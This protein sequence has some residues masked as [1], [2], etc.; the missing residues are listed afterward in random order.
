MLPY[1]GHRIFVYSRVTFHRLE[2]RSYRSEAIL[3]PYRIR[4]NVFSNYEYPNTGSV[5]TL[6][7]FNG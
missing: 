2:S 7:V 6:G 1:T 4:Y 5:T 3:T